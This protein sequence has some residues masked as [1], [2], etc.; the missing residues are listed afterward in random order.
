MRLYIR[1]SE[2]KERTGSDLPDAADG[3]DVVFITDAVREKAI[4]DLP[5]KDPGILTLQ[6]P[7]RLDMSASPGPEKGLT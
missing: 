7:D 2:E 6:L 3:R 5:G 4:S 1:G